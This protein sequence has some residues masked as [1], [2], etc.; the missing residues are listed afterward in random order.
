MLFLQLLGFGGTMTLSYSG[1]IPKT[2]EAQAD[3]PRNM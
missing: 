1:N 2:Q 3:S